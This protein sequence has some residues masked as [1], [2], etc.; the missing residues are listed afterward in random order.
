MGQRLAPGLAICFMSKIE[1]PVIERL[2]IMYCRYIDDCCVVTATQSEMDELFTILN[3]V[4]R[5]VV[6]NMFKQQQG[7]AQDTRSERNHEHLAG[8]RRQSLVTPL[9]KH[10]REAHFGADFD[11]RCTVLYHEDEIGIRKAL[12]VFWIHERNPSM[13]NRNECISITSE[14]LPFIPLCEL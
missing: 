2:P 8:K 14:F 12:E 6:R 11:V 4:K 13:N 10:R 3:T 9:G 7:C 1:R 5:V